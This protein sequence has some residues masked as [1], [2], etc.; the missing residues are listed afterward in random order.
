MVC[1]RFRTPFGCPPF[2]PASRSRLSA[3]RRCPGSF[4]RSCPS[5]LA[6]KHA[7][8]VL[9]L[10]S[11]YTVVSGR[12]ANRAINVSS[13][14]THVVRTDDSDNTNNCCECCLTRRG[15][16]L[17]AHRSHA[18]VTGW[19]RDQT[20]TAGGGSENW[21]VFPKNSAPRAG[22]RSSRVARAVA[23]RLLRSRRPCVS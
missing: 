17:R 22:R 7:R 16:C 11:S 1:C 15:V 10:L 5:K 21:D 4:V 8:P 12:H 9:V 18:G 19:R 2:Y 14:P 20:K 13:R 23:Q 6:A 3:R